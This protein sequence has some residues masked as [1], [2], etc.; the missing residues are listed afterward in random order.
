MTHK[1]R[2]FAAI[3]HRP[4]D[5]VPFATYNLH[6][7]G[8]VHRS[9]ASY[10]GLL[11]LVQAKA[12][13]LC[14]TGAAALQTPED[15][16]GGGL[17]DAQEEQEGDQVVTTRILRT[18]KGD[19]RS[20][21]R[22]PAGQ[23]SLVTEHFIKRDADIDRYMSLP[24]R[25]LEY[26]ASGMRRLDELLGGRG[27]VYASYPDPMYA[28]AVL[29]GFNDFAVR[30]ITD[31]GPVMRLIDFLFERI[32][33]DLG[34]LLAA[35]RGVDALFYTSGP[36]ICTPPMMAPELF[37]KLVNPYQSVLVRMIQDAGFPASLHCHGRVRLVLDDVLEI[38]FNALE[39]IEPPEQGDITL[40]E[41]LE[42]VGD[43]L[44]LVGH[45]QDQELH[46]VP[47][48]TMTRRVED[49]SRVVD[50]RSGY[51]M[52]PTCTPFQHP[53]AETFLRNYVEWVEAADL[54]L[55]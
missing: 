28:A 19:L 29:F 8:G 55:R 5:R 24:F 53:V 50:G 18:P 34:N 26:D 38:G 11:D 2:M 15:C 13:M 44:C 10:A 27:I 39:P 45:I 32:R 23:P 7:F 21:E 4:V 25:E 22:M 16:A 31:P 3:A 49:I 48:G 35:C 17:L 42:R 37:A 6:P 43:R 54:M 12:G 14:K 41:L 40:A 47:P 1:E 52:T 36:E 9:D 30:C 20:A 33:T 51:I 46:Y